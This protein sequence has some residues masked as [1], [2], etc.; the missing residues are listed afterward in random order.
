MQVRP[1]IVLLNDFLKAS[2][3]EPS[4]FSKIV[5][6]GD[7]ITQVLFEQHKI[8]LGRWLKIVSASI[9]VGLLLAVDDIVHLFFGGSYSPGD[10]VALNIL[11]GEDFVELLLE[12]TDKALL[13][14]LVP[15]T[16]GRTRSF[17]RGCCLVWS[18]QTR[19]QAIVVDIRSLV[20]T[21]E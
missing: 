2:V 4:E 1:Y 7:H 17:R 20:V 14:I 8:L 5:N 11:E 19:F 21:D 9:L 13:V 15:L 6:I 10:V 16:A 18:L 12:L 3:V